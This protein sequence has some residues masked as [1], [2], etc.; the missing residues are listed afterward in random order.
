MFPALK[1]WFK[2]LTTSRRRKTDTGTL[3]EQQAADFLKKKNYKIIARNWRSPRDRRD[4]L[5]LICDDRGILVFVEVKTRKVGALVPG[6]FEVNP[7][8]KRVILRA[9]KEYMRTLPA[10]PKTFRF[11]IIEVET[12]QAAVVEIRHYEN[13]RLFRGDFRF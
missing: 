5:D 4:E 6:F 1:N 8:K 11:D 7:R 9:S 12:R 13:I 10:H 3:G 2:K